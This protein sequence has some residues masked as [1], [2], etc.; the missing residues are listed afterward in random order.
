VRLA[1]STIGLIGGMVSF[2][3]VIGPIISIGLA[4]AGISISNA[5]DGLADEAAREKASAIR[6]EAVRVYR[7]KH[8]GTENYVYYS[9]VGAGA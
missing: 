2:I 4:I 6:D 3:P 1:G 5:A 9:D 7:Q 8:P